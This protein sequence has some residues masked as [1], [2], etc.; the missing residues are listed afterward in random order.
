MIVPSVRARRSESPVSLTAIIF[1]PASHHWPCHRWGGFERPDLAS[2]LRAAEVRSPSGT[3]TYWSEFY[4]SSSG[5]ARAGV[6][7]VPMLDA[8]ALVAAA[9]IGKVGI[10]EFGLLPSGT[11]W[12]AAGHWGKRPRNDTSRTTK[13]PHPRK[14][15]QWR[16]ERHTL[17]N[18]CDPFSWLVF[19]NRSAN[20]VLRSEPS[21][22][23]LARCSTAAVS[24]PLPF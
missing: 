12:P 4:S 23:T 9:P 3:A 7:A 15:A 17:A 21:R 11:G 14:P 18:F 8:F 24:C 20:Q 5:N 16:R 1:S 2:R 10:R 6:S 19:A 13:R 22:V